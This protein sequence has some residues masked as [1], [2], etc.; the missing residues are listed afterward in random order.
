MSE[1]D[2]ADAE[3]FLAEMLVI[4]PLLGVDAF[5]EV[6]RRE[7]G[8]EVERPDSGEPDLFLRQRGAEGRGREAASGFVVCAGSRARA[9]ETGSI[10]P[11]LSEKR[12]SLTENGI[13]VREGEVLRF[14]KDHRFT[15]PSMAAG[16]LVGGS[17]NGL[18]AWKDKTRRDLKTLRGLSVEPDQ[19][20]N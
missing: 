11:Y 3:W 5:E 6:E 7:S 14:T 13:M 12:R 8:E 10:H 20:V 2:Q 18:K 16:V 4:F 15:S 9:S 1:A 17:A 19:P